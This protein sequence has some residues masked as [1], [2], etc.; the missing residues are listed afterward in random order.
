MH[1]PTKAWLLAVIV[2]A[3]FACVACGRRAQ[4]KSV[5]LDIPGT[6]P[7]RVAPIDMEPNA[8]QLTAVG[9]S[10]KRGRPGWQY[11]YKDLY[12]LENMLRESIP[13]RG[14]A[15]TPFQIHLVIRHVLVATSSSYDA[16]IACV[17]WALTDPNERLIF[18]EQFYVVPSMSSRGLAG[19]KNQMHVAI[20]ARVHQTAQDVASGRPPAPASRDT[21]DDFDSA[22]S[23]VPPWLT[24]YV[25]IWEGPI[26]SIGRTVGG[27]SQTHLVHQ[28]DYIDWYLRLGISRPTE[29][30]APEEPP[31]PTAPRPPGY[32]PATHP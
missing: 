6:H 3:V 25:S 20:T 18:D 11:G 10:P 13:M 28:R 32:P 23:Q 2:Y 21:Y 15:R 22:A 4:V 1:A 26:L 24:S 16:V 8:S 5:T 30:R 17:A 29:P 31:Q 12:L 9:E 14:G 7:V 27:P 19:M